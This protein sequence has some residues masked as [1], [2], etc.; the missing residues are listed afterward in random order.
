MDLVLEN[1]GLIGI[2]TG[3][4]IGSLFCKFIA[5]GKNNTQTDNSIN[6][7]NKSDRNKK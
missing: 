6:I 1:S 4:F 7:K 5:I 2:V 3:I